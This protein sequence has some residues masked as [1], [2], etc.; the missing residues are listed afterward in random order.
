MPNG[1]IRPQCDKPGHNI[2][3]STDEFSI[4]PVRQLGLSLYFCVMQMR[5]TADLSTASDIVS[6]VAPEKESHVECHYPLSYC[7]L[8]KMATILQTLTSQCI[9][10]I[11]HNTFSHFMKV[12]SDICTL[13]LISFGVLPWVSILIGQSTTDGQ[14]PLTHLPLDKMAAISQTTFSNTFSWMKMLEFQFNFPWNLF[15]RFQLTI[16]QHWVR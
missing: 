2:S 13:L 16:H 12:L 3:F 6:K 10:I 1:I 5:T 4:L 14:D 8:S 9:N 11:L 7:S 15:L